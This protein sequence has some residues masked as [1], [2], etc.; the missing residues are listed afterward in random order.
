MAG[1]AANGEAALEIIPQIDPDVVTMDVNMPVM[2]GL[3][4]LKHMM[5]ETPTPTV[6]V[7]TLTQEGASVTFDALKFGAVDFVNKPSKMDESKLEGQEDA[8]ARKVALAAQVE[9]EA[10]RYIRDLPKGESAGPNGQVACNR[11]IAMG[12]AEGGYGALLKI[13]PHLRPDLPAAYLAVLYAASQHV[14][15]FARYLDNFSSVR[16]PTAWRSKAG[17]ATWGP[18]R[19]TSRCSHATATFFCRSTPLPSNQFQ[20]AEA[21]ST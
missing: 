10:I 7:S 12:A 3:T 4:T 5:I 20:S 18:A 9:I 13:V 16:R 2:D 1:E 6:M 15:A 8:V 21:R 11:L 14:D 19:S 17:F